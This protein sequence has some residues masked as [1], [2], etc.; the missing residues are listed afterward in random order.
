MVAVVIGKS[1][2]VIVDLDHL[3]DVRVAVA[4]VRETGRSPHPRNRLENSLD[5]P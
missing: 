3:L 5:A 4:Q 1:V 2:V